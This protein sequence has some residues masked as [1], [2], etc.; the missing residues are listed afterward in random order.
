MTS[1]TR[2]KVLGVF[3]FLLVIVT[4]AAVLP[5]LLKPDLPVAVTFRRASVSNK[6]YVAQF[7]NG[8]GRYLAVRAQF[9]NT[10]MKQKVERG[11]ELPPERNARWPVEVG[12][13]EGW[14]F[15]SGETIHITHEDYRSL[16]V[17]VP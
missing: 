7:S 2:N 12:W 5:H 14:K 3:A 9:E 4:A 15:V 8:S 11:I 17:I 1:S 13:Q 10:T 6:G 16:T